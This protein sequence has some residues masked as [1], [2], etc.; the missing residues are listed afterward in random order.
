M[1]KRI[2]KHGA[3]YGAGELLARMTA[4]LLVPV[5][6]VMLA[7]EELAVW[8]L[9]AMALQLLN[10]SYGVGLSAAVLQFQY[11]YKD[12]PEGLRVFNGTIVTFLLFWPLV[13]HGGLELGAPGL[14]QAWLPQLPWAPYGRLLSLT[15]LLSTATLVPIAF[16]T[17][18]EKP[19]PFVLL[20][21]A[22]ALLETLLTLGLLVMAGWGVLSIFAGR[23]A[24]ALLV[25]APL[26][27]ATARKVRLG[28]RWHLLGP[29]L[30]FGIPLL[31]HLLSTWALTMADR[32]LLV[33][34]D[35]QH[36]LGIYTAAYWF[37]IAVNV[38][39]MS[40]YRSWS[41]LFHKTVTDEEQRPA[42]LRA[43]TVFVGAVL[44]ASVGAASV[45]PDVVHLVFADGYHSG[46]QLAS[47]LVLGAGF[48]GLYLVQVA[49][50]YNRKRK[51]AIPIASG[52]AAV[53]NIA[54]NLLWIPEHGA[55][56]AAWATLV[57]YGVLAGVT[58]AFAR[59]EM[60]LPVDLR[61]VVASLAG[62]ALAYLLGEL[63]ASA[64][65]AGPEAG[66]GALLGVLALKA[67]VFLG[68]AAG[69]W[70]VLRD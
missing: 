56:G 9:G 52:S 45:A 61:V 11:D 40:A 51:L 33:R 12:D 59:R 34:L 3:I 39:S 60:K 16:W 41:P 8:G 15:A 2:V 49:P 30:A 37:P 21:T 63:A 10:T 14:L 4:F 62:V 13:L 58:A 32:V 44:F 66:V 1:L 5:Y 36:S 54:L 31:P 46:A 50:L 48:Q 53:T 27:I 67:T 65:G 29:A 43:T 24:G 42:L 57:S 68:I 47:V 35:G 38:L 69:C 28:I 25:A 19:K 20:N 26:G 70:R 55:I 17:A 64:V 22:K 23:L 7:P 6:T 18:G